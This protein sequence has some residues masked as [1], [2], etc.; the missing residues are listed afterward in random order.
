MLTFLRLRIF[1]YI[2][3]RVNILPFHWICRTKAFHKCK[4]LSS[5]FVLSAVPEIDIGS[6]WGSP[7]NSPLEC[8]RNWTDRRTHAARTYR[9]TCS[10]P[11]GVQNDRE[12]FT[13]LF[14]AAGARD[15]HG[16]CASNYKTFRSGRV[17][18]QN[19]IAVL[20]SC[21][22]RGI[23]SLYLVYRHKVIIVWVHYFE[24]RESN[25]YRRRARRSRGKKMT[26]NDRCA[27]VV[28]LTGCL[29]EVNTTLAQETIDIT[30][31]ISVK[32]EQRPLRHSSD[33][34]RCPNRRSNRTRSPIKKYRDFLEFKS[35]TFDCLPF[36]L[37]RYTLLLDSYSVFKPSCRF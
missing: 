8:T 18:T 6:S 15:S 24:R 23:R 19:D 2:V 9:A 1:A 17:W 29:F 33:Y 21:V 31:H 7:V 20:L 25:Y 12:I 14:M 4:I 16:D 11:F 26:D 3:W 27:G 37:P 28:S 34:Y 30:N 22:H 13:R 36:N 5:V 35:I 10:L 32:C